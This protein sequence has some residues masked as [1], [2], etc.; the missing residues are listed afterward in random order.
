MQD[1][2]Q[3]CSSIVH[4]QMRN[5][6]SPVDGAFDPQGQTTAV[7][8]RLEGLLA[9]ME[10]LPHDDFRAKVEDA[11]RRSV[12]FLL[13]AQIKSGTYAGGMPGAVRISALN[14]SQIRI[15]YVQH[16]LCAWL[17]YEEVVQSE[18]QVR[19]DSRVR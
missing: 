4:Q 14:S 11:V 15:D 1:A 18:T 10:F 16:A 9:A 2:F 19:V 8:A 6:A 3:I 5:P 7:A 12:A 17:R 13:R